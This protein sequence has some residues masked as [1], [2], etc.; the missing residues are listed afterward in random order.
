MKTIIFLTCAAAAVFENLN[1][2]LPPAPVE[3]AVRSFL[4][5]YF[6]ILVILGMFLNSLILFLVYKFVKLRTAALSSNLTLAVIRGIPN[7]VHHVVG[8]WIHS[9]QL[10]TLNGFAVVS[11]IQS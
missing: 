9:L 2:T 6:V 4:V 3:L 1:S 7:I 11:L 8:S 5:V 10:C